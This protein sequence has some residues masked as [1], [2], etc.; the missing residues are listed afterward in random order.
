M[1]A[2][3]EAFHPDRKLLVGGDGITIEEFLSK[4][5]EHWVG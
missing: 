1:A 4:P 2:F 3:S 5:M